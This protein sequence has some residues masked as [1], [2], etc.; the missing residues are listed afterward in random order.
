MSSAGRAIGILAQLE[1]AELHI[2]GIDQ[3]EA[4]NQGFAFAQN[5]LYDFGRLHYADQPWQDAQH[6]A[7]GAGWHQT[8]RWW[9]GIQA[10]IARAVPGR[11]HAGLAF[12]AED[13]SV[14]VRLAGEHT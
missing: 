10:A 5:Q 11:K 6:A 4:A 3:Q 12:E 1:F 7:F 14:D 2:Q 8:R 13:R 9:L